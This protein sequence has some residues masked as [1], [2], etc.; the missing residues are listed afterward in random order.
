MGGI[1]YGIGTTRK[2]RRRN[3]FILRAITH[4]TTLLNSSAS[5][6]DNVSGFPFASGES[7][8]LNANS[9]Y[10]L[11]SNRG[12][13]TANIRCMKVFMTG[14]NESSSGIPCQL[15]N[16]ISCSGT[17]CSSSQTKTVTWGSNPTA[18]ATQSV[19]IGNNGNIKQYT[20]NGATLTHASVITTSGS[21]SGR[22]IALNN[23][24]AYLSVGVSKTGSIY[25]SNISSNGSLTS[26]GTIYPSFSGPQSTALNGAYAYIAIYNG[27]NGNGSTVSKCSVSPTTGG[28]SACNTVLVNLPA[29]PIQGAQDI[30]INNGYLYLVGPA[31][32]AIKC[33]VSSSDGSLSSCS[34]QA[35]FAMTGGQGI[36]IR[37]GYAY[38]T[39]TTFT[40]SEVYACPLDATT[41]VIGTCAL[42]GSGFSGPRGIRIN[43]GYAYIAN[44]NVK[45]VSI[46]S[47][48]NGVLSS[49]NATTFADSGTLANPWGIGIF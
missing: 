11:A 43:N 6:I 37:D 17:S 48:A 23:G 29:V 18:C 15:F 39:R 20:I 34:Y 12:I 33:S 46:C 10:N 47:V 40:N 19:Y 49:C 5:V 26:T 13:T 7:F 4:C 8:Q 36:A 14:S 3:R 24:V 16:D 27:N 30:A 22:G 38:I 2:K 32:G 25:L 9:V 35:T 31:S 42:T 41:G 45:S 28:L 44:Y 1:K 21:I